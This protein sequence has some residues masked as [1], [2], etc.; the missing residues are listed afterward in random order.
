MMMIINILQ[1]S[2]T[3]DRISRQELVYKTGTTDRAVRTEIASLR[4]RGWWI[5]SDTS[6]GG[7]WLGDANEWN[8]FCRQQKRRAASNY[9]KEAHENKNQI[10]LFDNLG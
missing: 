8:N 7:Y 9:Y 6:K 2:T 10:D 4:H 3:E 5:V 1:D